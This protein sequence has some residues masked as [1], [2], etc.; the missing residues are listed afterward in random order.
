MLAHAFDTAPAG[1][2]YIVPFLVSAII[3]PPPPRQSSRAP[4]NI[5]LPSPAAPA[6]TRPTRHRVF[7]AH[8]AFH[9]QNSTL[10]THTLPRCPTIPH[11]SAASASPLPPPFGAPQNSHIQ[12]PPAGLSAPKYARTPAL[13][14]WYCWHSNGFSQWKK[15]TWELR[16]KSAAIHRKQ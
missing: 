3:S 13:P 5:P 4:L 7:P 14:A 15:W 11:N 12:T 8:S 1:A 10:R 6:H 9:P 16:K 2:R